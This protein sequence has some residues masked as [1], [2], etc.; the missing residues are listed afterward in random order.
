MME[1]LEHGLQGP[2]QGQGRQS[3]TDADDQ[4]DGH[5]QGPVV[6]AE[7]GPAG[8]FSPYVE[9]IH[10]AEFSKNGNVLPAAVPLITICNKQ[11]QFEKLQTDS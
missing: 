1:P 10:K 11:E 8:G 3:R 9:K 5:E 4:A 7:H 2:V 6:H